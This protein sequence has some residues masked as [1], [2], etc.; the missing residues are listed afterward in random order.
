VPV[1]SRLF[2]RRFLKELLRVYQAGK[3]SF[4]GEHAPLM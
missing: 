4:F 3:P 1:L 2:R